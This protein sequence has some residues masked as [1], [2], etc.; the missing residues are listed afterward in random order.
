M[1]CSSSMG[2]GKPVSKFDYSAM[3]GV[4]FGYLAMRENE[5][6]QYSTFAEKLDVFQSRRGMSQLASMVSHLN[7]VQMKGYSKFRDSILQY[8][9]LIGS[10]AL[11]VIVSDLLMDINEII[12]G[13]YLLGENEVKIIQILD[14]IEK[15]LQMQGDFKLI[16][17]ESRQRLR[18]YIS[19]RLRVNYQRIL[20]EHCA[21]IEE[22]CNR[23]GYHYFLA[24]TDT[25]IFDTFYRVLE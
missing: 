3:L 20:D 8:K 5:K 6:F 12:E 13:L 15:N 21:K 10:R 18:T 16:D 22:V 23:L 7:G 11:L 24:T 19:P 14:P 17:S 9:K 1:D 25:P 2:F 4:G